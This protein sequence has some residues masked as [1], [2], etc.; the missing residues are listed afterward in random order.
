M[1]TDD[2]YGVLDPSTNYS[3]R[4]ETA[5]EGAVS[6]RLISLLIDELDSF[7]GQ[8]EG[9]RIPPGRASGWYT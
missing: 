5:A 6:K 4:A 2:R 8:V 3:A 9:T 1:A 7:G